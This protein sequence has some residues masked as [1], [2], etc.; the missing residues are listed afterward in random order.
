MLVWPPNSPDLNLIELLW[1][2]L[3]LDTI[4]GLVDDFRRRCLLVL[5]NRGE[6]IQKYISGGKLKEVTDE[7]IFEIINELN[8]S[9]IELTEIPDIIGEKITEEEFDSIVKA[10]T[11]PPTRPT[12]RWTKEKEQI[13]MLCYENY[14]N[15]YEK[16]QEKFTEKVTIGA[17][18]NRLYKILKERKEKDD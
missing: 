17:L 12:V 6:N 2:E 11:K 16:M 14:G 18:K 10:N 8:E 4:N 15:D 3:S 9:G 13:I 1:D 5:Q 7:E